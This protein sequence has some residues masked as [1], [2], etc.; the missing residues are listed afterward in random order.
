MLGVLVHTK[1]TYTSCEMHPAFAWRIHGGGG[2]SRTH[3]PTLKTH[4]P[5]PTSR[6]GIHSKKKKP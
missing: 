4:K 3:P 1:G 5:T 6:Q 2:F